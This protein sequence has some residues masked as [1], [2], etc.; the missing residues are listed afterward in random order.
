MKIFE[1]AEV[2]FAVA[3]AYLLFNIGIRAGKLNKAGSRNLFVSSLLLMLGM[4]SYG[5]QGCAQ[6][7]ETVSS[8]ALQQDARGTYTVR[9][10]SELFGTRQWEQFRDFWKKLDLISPKDGKYEQS[11]SVQQY[12]DLKDELRAKVSGLN[13]L[14]REMI[15]SEEVNLLQQLCDERI[16]GYSWDRTILSRMMPPPSD[17]IKKQLL[18]DMENKIDILMELKASGKVSSAE[19]NKALSNIQE[20]IEA[21]C[22]L[23]IIRSKYSRR[24]RYFTAPP[25]LDGDTR[26]AID[27]SMKSLEN[28]HSGYIG[29]LKARSDMTPDERIS[30]ED[31]EKQYNET[32]KAIEHLKTIMP[33]FD[34][35]IADLENG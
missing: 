20:D 28:D 17:H 9:P 26:G 19:F 21:I 16:D 2:L 14:D 29:K 22:G 3:I 34:E 1:A 25:L 30:F 15:S 13:S 11:I 4:L 31:T 35:L 10:V 32:K 23:D 33:R 24:S 5:G 7:Q 8:G 6:Q 27:E 12:R 18:S